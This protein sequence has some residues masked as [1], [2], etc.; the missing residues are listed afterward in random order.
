MSSGAATGGAGPE[1][2]LVS[3][4]SR[5]NM[6]ENSMM[7]PQSAFHG[8]GQSTDAPGGRLGGAATPT[9]FDIAG[10]FAQDSQLTPYAQQLLYKPAALHYSYQNTN[11]RRNIST[12]RDG[13]KGGFYHN[14]PG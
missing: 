3:N 6:L 10:S 11:E 2:A 8:A 14:Q 4:G 5:S 13:K 1:A 9:A 7:P 12:G